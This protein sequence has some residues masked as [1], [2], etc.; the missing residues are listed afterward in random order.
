M[1]NTRPELEVDRWYQDAAT[2]NTFRIVAF[3]RDADSIEVQYFN[4]DLAEYDFASWAESQ[5]V[6]IEAPEDWTGP[7]D[8]VELD[9]FG[10]SD[11]DLHEPHLQDLTLDD[12]LDDRDE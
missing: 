2:G 5:F 3:D 1:M 12:L 7:F 4:G 10:Y 8:D 11:P 6:P 9:D